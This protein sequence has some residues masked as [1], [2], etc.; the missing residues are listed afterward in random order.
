MFS[1]T[2]M[3]SLNQQSPSWVRFKSKPLPDAQIWAMLKPLLP[4]EPPKP[5][6]GRPRVSNRRAVRGILFVLRNNVPWETLPH[7]LGCGSGL[8]CLR[9]FKEWEKAGVWDNLSAKLLDQSEFHRFVWLMEA[10]SSARIVTK[11]GRL[12]SRAKARRLGF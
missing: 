9:R 4:Q 1:Y 3:T 7:S 2:K 11:A 8:T 10:L 5:T 12:R 6:G